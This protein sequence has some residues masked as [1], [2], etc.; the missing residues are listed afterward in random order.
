[1]STLITVIGNC[2]SGKTTL[3]KKLSEHYGFTPLLE[4]HA[5]RPFQ[6]KFQ[7]ELKTFALA[8]QID[9]LLYR[10]E[11]EFSLR[12]SGKNGI[13]DGGLDQDFYVFTRLFHRKGLLEDRE[14]ALCERL[15]H[16]MRQAL[17]MPDLIIRLTA[18][19]DVLIQRR[20]ARTRALDIVTG[21]DLPV[22]DGLINVWMNANIVP[23]ILFDTT[24]NDPDYSM[25][26]A[27]LLIALSGFLSV[28]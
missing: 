21:A 23:V 9:Y 12:E 16:A 25:T 3:A 10:A 19:L 17:P 2:G 26:I 1:M 7:A 27:P 15:Y 28:S 14:Y 8:N 5:E 20:A 22:I 4:Q 18:P 6:A 24:Q 11:Q 13:A